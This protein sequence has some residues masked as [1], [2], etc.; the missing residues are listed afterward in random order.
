MQDSNTAKVSACIDLYV[1]IALSNRIF[2]LRDVRLHI[3]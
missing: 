2:A 3:A 1:K